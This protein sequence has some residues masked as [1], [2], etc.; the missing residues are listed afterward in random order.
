MY[1][2]ELLLKTIDEEFSS[3]GSKCKQAIYFHLEKS[4]KIKKGDI[5]YRIKEFQEAIENIFGAGAKVLQIRIMKNL[6]KKIGHPLPHFHNQESL[7]F[8]NYLNLARDTHSKF[9]QSTTTLYAK[10]E[11][12]IDRITRRMSNKVK[13]EKFGYLTYIGWRH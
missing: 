3:L 10:Q 1:F 2:E 11:V 13:S 8:T 5:P 6:F 12:Y 9:L 4:F 7:E